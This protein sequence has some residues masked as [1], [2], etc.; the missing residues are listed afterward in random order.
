MV[1]I[2]TT[3][4][5]N[6]ERILYEDNHLIVVD[7]PAGIATMGTD[8]H[9]ASLFDQIKNYIKTKYAKPGNVYLGVT[10]RIDM[11]VSGVIAF[12]KTSKAASRISEQF[13]KSEVQ[14]SYYAVLEGTPS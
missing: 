1:S 6:P 3:T 4:P 10:S 9:E 14:K 13:R 12:A 11:F 8:H 5:F 2:I 7:K